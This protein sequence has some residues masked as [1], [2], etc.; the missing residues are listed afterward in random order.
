M[1]LITKT[2]TCT[3]VLSCFV[4]VNK[5]CK[6]IWKKKF[7]CYVFLRITEAIE[8]T[9]E[10]NSTGII[11]LEALCAHLPKRPHN[12]ALTHVFLLSSGIAILRK[13]GKD[14]NFSNMF[15]LSQFLL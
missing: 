7:S 1:P 13:G 10:I 9:Q 15:C 11:P 2:F 8:V 3:C 14:S 12:F 4:V 5:L 6:S